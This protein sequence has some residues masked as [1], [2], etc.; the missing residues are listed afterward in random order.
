MWRILQ[1]KVQLFTSM[2]SFIMEYSIKAISKGI[3]YS[4]IGLEDVIELEKDFLK[5]EVWK[6]INDSGKGTCLD[7]FNIAFF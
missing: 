7:G 3:S 2:R 4:T 1:Q 6:A 5:E